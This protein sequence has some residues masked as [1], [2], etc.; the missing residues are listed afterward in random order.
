MLKIKCPSCGNEVVIDDNQEAV[1]MSM[2]KDSAFESSVEKRAKELVD[3]KVSDLEQKIKE[4]DAVRKS[5]RES[6]EKDKEVAI[7]NATSALEKKLK[8][9][10]AKLDMVQMQEKLNIEKATATLEKRLKKVEGEAEKIRLE[11]NLN[12][13][14][15]TSELESQLKERETELAKAKLDGELAV[16]KVT[17]DIKAQLAEKNSEIDRIR[18]VADSEKQLAVANAV[19]KEKARFESEKAE[20][21]K[22]ETELNARL[23]DQER[24]TEYYKDLKTR[25]STKMVGETLEQHCEVQFNQIRMTAFPNAYFEKDNDD[26]TGSKGDYIFRE[27]DA[28]GTEIISIMFEM[29]NQ[30]ETTASK[31]KNKDFFKELDKDRREKKCEYAVLVSLLEAD[32]ELYN[33]GIVD[34]SYEYEKMYVIRPQCFIPMITLLRNAALN[35]LVYKNELALVKEEQI[36]LTNFEENLLAFKDAFSKNYEMAHSHFDRAVS[37]IDKAIKTLE[38]VRE[39]LMKSDRQYRLASNKA[40]DVTI[41]K[42]TK[43]APSVAEQLKKQTKTKN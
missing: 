5:E 17:S 27:Y 30:M 4:Q 21:E 40:E 42:L 13:A 29:K 8:D 28:N 11:S 9:A 7:L 38:T 33:A 22:R 14:K 10:E 3:V 34:V 23:K 37:E 2:V 15:A 24:E 35:A 41:K 39:F 12:V 20:F 25:M 31:H 18:S 43:N 16:A 19:A 32:S 26:R 1:V 6:L 36:D